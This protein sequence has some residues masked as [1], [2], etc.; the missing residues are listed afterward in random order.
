MHNGFI[1]FEDDKEIRIASDPLSNQPPIVIPKSEIERE[2]LSDLSPMPAGT[3]NSFDQIQILDLL[4]YIE[5]RGNADHA[6]FNDAPQQE[7]E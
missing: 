6:V 5:S 2:K 4:A 1:V 3:L 7:K